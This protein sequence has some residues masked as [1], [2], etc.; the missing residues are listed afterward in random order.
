MMFFKPAVPAVLLSSLLLTFTLPADA[1]PKQSGKQARKATTQGAKLR[2]VAAN[3]D[4]AGEVAN[5]TQ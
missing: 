1:S 4:E 3:P 5:F 2:K